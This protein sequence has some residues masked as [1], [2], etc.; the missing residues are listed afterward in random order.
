MVGA[1]AKYLLHLHNVL[2][3]LIGRDATFSVCICR[4]FCSQ[5][6]TDERG[7][8]YGKEKP[9]HKKGRKHRMFSLQLD[10]CNVYRY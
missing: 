10:V 2:K 1:S 4:L 9:A 3:S 5:G 6:Q 7:R 8:V